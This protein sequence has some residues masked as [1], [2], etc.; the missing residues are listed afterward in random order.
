MR[1]NFLILVLLGAAL[2]LFSQQG[3]ID[4]PHIRWQ[5]DAGAPVRGGMAIDGDRLYFGNSDGVL[6]CL[7]KAAGRLVW[8][9]KTGGAITCTPAVA[10]GKVIFQSRDNRV[11]ALKA[12]TGKPAWQFKMQGSAP[13]TWGWD[14]YT[15]MPVISGRQVLIG[16]GDHHL[17]ALDLKTGKET[18]SFEAGDKIRAAPLVA[19]NRLF[20][21]AFDGYV[22]VLDPATGAETG[23]FKT[24]GVGYYDKVY[25]WDRT[26][27]TGQ[28]ALN[29]GRLVFGSRDGG[30]YCI[31]ARTLEQKWRFAYGASWV[32]S[33]PVIDGQTVFVGWSDQLVF[34]AFDLETG[35]ERWQYNC[36]AYVYATPV[37][38][39]RNVYAGSFN[40]KVY[41]F[42]KETGKVAWE[43]Q[44]GNAVLSSPALE[45][46]VLYIGSDNGRVYAFENGPP[47]F[48]AVYQ[49]R[50]IVENELLSD[51]RIAPWLEEQ[52][53]Q[54][55]DTT[56]LGQFM[57]D[58]IRDGNPSV[59]VFAHE[60]LPGDVSGDDP[61]Q[62]LLKKYMESGGK[63]VWL[64]FLPKYWTPDKD[65]NIVAFN[66]GY[67]AKLL[68]LD[69]DIHMD[70]G[71]YY[72]KTTNAGL[73]WGLPAEFTAPGS[74]IGG[75][76]GLVVLAANE[77]GRIV[78]FYKP[79]GNRP[80][81]GFVSFRSWS[82]TPIR[83][84]D[85]MTIM[86]VAEHGL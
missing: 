27:I 26:S 59:V 54:R 80:G 32:G 55:L 83:E 12:S 81:A 19:E 62:S 63:V 49:P 69:F 82:L 37:T 28:P 3:S 29:N 10:D 11:Y 33:A 85:M 56:D 34:S 6:F 22:Y 52:G 65:L 79:F 20:V 42:E 68:G 41:G 76:E 35:K 53:Y 14:Y 77:F 23:K 47:T 57:R 38:D 7:D 9:F 2:P 45:N 31:D 39:S 13:H 67:S 70:F 43:F 61:D 48:K 40:G 60:Y 66:P 51:K 17:Y 25:G 21:P 8:Q 30:L 5:Y 75:G 44:T 24:E 84:A 18:W 73:E 36:K 46:G 1:A 15:P 16:S 50:K 4:H 72:A 74:T 86:A 71:T 58:R 64:A 78:S